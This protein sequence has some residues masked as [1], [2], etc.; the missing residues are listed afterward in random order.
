MKLIAEGSHGT[1]INS[2]KHAFNILIIKV[3]RMLEDHESFEDEDGSPTTRTKPS[4]TLFSPLPSF[5]PSCIVGF[6]I[7]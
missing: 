1:A 3:M 5:I 6:R 7:S 2:Q 4:R